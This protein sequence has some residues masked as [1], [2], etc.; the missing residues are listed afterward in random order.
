MN[1]FFGFKVQTVNESWRL[2]VFSQI[3]QGNEASPCTSRLWWLRAVR[4][5]FIL[6]QISHTWG[7]SV[8]IFK[9]LFSVP[10]F[11]S[12]APQKVHWTRGSSMPMCCV[13]MWSWKPSFVL[14]TFAH[15]SQMRWSTRSCT[16]KMCILSI[17]SDLKLFQWSEKEKKRYSHFNR[18]NQEN[19]VSCILLFTN[20]ANEFRITDRMYVA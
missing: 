14:N 19:V 13:F 20:V 5:G 16:F 6:W 4:V 8:W 18:P 1:G 11:F 10:R 17:W 2:N 9:C 7:L 15:T 12:Q 3:V